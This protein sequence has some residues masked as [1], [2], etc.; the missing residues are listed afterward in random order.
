MVSPLPRLTLVLGGARSGKSRHAEKLATALPAPWLYVA[1]AQALDDEMAERIAHHRAL[2][3]EGWTTADAPWDVAGALRSA[4]ASAV[5]IDCLT[6]WLSNVMLGG[7][8]VARE[9]AVL[10]DALRQ[11]PVPIVA[12]SNEVGLGIVP[13]NALARAFRD[14]QGR[15]NAAVAERADHVVFMAAGLPLVLKGP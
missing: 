2:R 9:Q 8:D 4:T 15:L 13:E 1:T 12:V 10:L 14:A 5:L 7:G 11:A 3:G 6:L